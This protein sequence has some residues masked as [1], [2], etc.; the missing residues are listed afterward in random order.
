MVLSELN[1]SIPSRI[2]LK[3]ILETLSVDTIIKKG[4]NLPCDKIGIALREF[5]NIDDIIGSKLSQ[6]IW[7]DKNIKDQFMSSLNNTNLSSSV[8][9]LSDIRFIDHDFAIHQLNELLLKNR[10]TEYHKQ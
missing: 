4:R 3:G 10:I 1:T 2:L 7:E 8:K 9:A 5:Q 6:L